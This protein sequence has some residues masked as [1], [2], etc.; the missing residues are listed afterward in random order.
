METAKMWY[1]FSKNYEDYESAKHQKQNQTKT[2]QNREQGDSW[3]GRR[4][5]CSSF[6]WNEYNLDQ[7]IT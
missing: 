1:I 2:T 5:R 4:D 3:R 6:L 7:N